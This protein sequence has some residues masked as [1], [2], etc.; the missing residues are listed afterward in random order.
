MTDVPEYIKCKLQEAERDQSVA[1][2][3][4]DDYTRRA[5]EMRA[6]ATEFDIV[7]RYLRNLARDV[8]IVV[9]KSEAP[10]LGQTVRQQ[11]IDGLMDKPPGIRALVGEYL[12][13]NYLVMSNDVVQWVLERHPDA[14]QDSVRAE[15]SQRKKKGD[16]KM[17]LDGSLRSTIFNRPLTE[18]NDPMD[19]DDSI[20][21]A[22]NDY[23]I[24]QQN[25][26]NR[27]HE[28]G[29]NFGKLSV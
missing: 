5:A 8:G 29:P 18:E 26:G 16:I 20:S 3:K 25:G 22:E 17:L 19:N 21:I 14:K 23:L 12:T 1:M 7:L 28:P 15:L 2:S 11:P 4:A 9:E 6:K 27:H 10:S 13:S 24:A